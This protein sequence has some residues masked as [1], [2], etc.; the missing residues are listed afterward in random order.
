M[1]PGGEHGQHQFYLDHQAVPLVKQPLGRVAPLFVVFAEGCEL[2]PAEVWAIR[3]A[4]APNSAIVDFTYKRKFLIF[5]NAC[6]KKFFVRHVRLGG[7]PNM[8]LGVM[9]ISSIPFWGTP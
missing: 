4:R 2:L 1:T 9:W 3:A 6:D 5:Q 7:Y 8:I